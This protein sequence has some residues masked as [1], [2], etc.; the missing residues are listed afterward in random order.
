MWLYELV[1]ENGGIY[2]RER[3]IDKRR[4]KER[5]NISV[6]DE[7]YE[8][9]CKEDVRYGMANF[10]LTLNDGSKVFGR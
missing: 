1:K 2:L 9:L 5:F 3:M 4:I 7:N 10:V 8:N 6:V